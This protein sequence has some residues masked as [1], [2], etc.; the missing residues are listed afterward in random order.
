MYAFG[1][2]QDKALVSFSD[3]LIGHGDNKRS[4][5]D[6]TKPR[7]FKTRQIGT[8][9]QQPAAAAVEGI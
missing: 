5:Q 6:K 8:R 4:L 9:K 1:T 2:C 7:L 3:V